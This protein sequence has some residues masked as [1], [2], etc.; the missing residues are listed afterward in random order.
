[1]QK[2]IQSPVNSRIDKHNVGYY[3]AVKNHLERTM[4]KHPS[5]IKLNERSQSHT[6]I[7]NIK[8]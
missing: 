7:L 4:W 6:A 5:K 1:M 8:L 2:Q 3:I